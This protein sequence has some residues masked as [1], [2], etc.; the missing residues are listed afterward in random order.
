MDKLIYT[1]TTKVHGLSLRSLNDS[2]SIKN[3]WAYVA[4]SLYTVGWR[5]NNSYSYFPSL[6]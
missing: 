5:K 2:T 4:V 1:Y 3:V 6:I